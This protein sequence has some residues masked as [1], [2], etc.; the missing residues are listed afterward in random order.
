MGGIGD[1]LGG[2]GDSLSGAVNSQGFWPAAIVAGGSLLNN[3]FNSPEDYSG[4]Q[5][6]LQRDKFESDKALQQQQLAQA[7]EIAKLQLAARG[8]GGAGSALAAARL[9]DATRRKELQEAQ[10]QNRLQNALA[11]AKMKQPELLTS[12]YGQAINQTGQAGAT[13]VNA[14]GQLVQA[15]QNPLLRGVGGR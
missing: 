12:A 4:Q 7:L 9:A 13:N 2:I 5:L 3:L 8:D 14:F 15:L 10:K 11:A 1:F 6:A